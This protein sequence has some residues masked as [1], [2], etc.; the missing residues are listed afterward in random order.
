MIQKTRFFETLI[1]LLIL[2]FLGSE[3]RVSAQKRV[4]EFGSESSLAHGAV[5][6][7][8]TD[9]YSPEKGYGFEPGTGV[10]CWKGTSRKN[11]NCTSNKPFYFSTALP[12]GNYRVSVRFGDRQVATS[13][14][15]KAE[16]RRLMIESIETNPGEF[17]TRTFIVNV[18]KPQISTGGEVKLKDREKTSERWAWDEKLT[19]EFN[20]VRPTINS[21][22]IQKV[23]VPTVFLLGDSTVCDQPSEPYASWGQMITRFF[24]G[25]IA[26]AN[27]AESGESL[28]SSLGAKRLEKVLSLIKPG[29]FLM[30]QY[31]HND[32]KEKGDGIGAF[33]SY[34]ASL[35]QFTE[36]AK[37]KGASVTLINPMHRR[38]FDASGKITNSHGDYPEAVRQAAKEE[39]VPLIDLTA[40]SKDLYEALGKD[41]SGVLFKAGDGTH[42]NNYGSYQL[43][44]TIVQAIRDQKL[45]LAK[46]LIKG[47]T[48]F[49]PK[50]PDDLK[51]F[52]IPASPA[53]TDLKPLG[54]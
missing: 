27:H 13:T 11:G 39:N 28:K 18:R 3:L 12:E 2:L 33:T 48:K 5:T 9:I 54:S 43:A 10:L 38:T 46:F 32:E 15:V 4:Y 51:T 8:G 42:H 53:V 45:P 26:V 40:M 22:E 1:L 14:V 7:L 31:G 34:K 50:K 6:V 16:L 23:D 25:K 36:A 41:G 49:D 35:K 44:K 47:L 30:I 52:A 24:D 20:G 21:I 17:L 37:A 19:L 29:D